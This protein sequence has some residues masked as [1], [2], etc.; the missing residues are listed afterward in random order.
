ML[1]RRPTFP[2]FLEAPIFSTLQHFNFSTQI[3]AMQ[4]II[5]GLFLFFAHFLLQAQ[6]LPA[7]KSLIW[8]ISG[9]GLKKNSYLYGT[10]HLI[11]RKDFFMHKSTKEAFK[12]TEKVTFEID[13]KEMENIFA[14]IPL[15]MQSFMK[16]DTSLRDL[17]PAEDYKLV[18]KHFSEIGL[19][20]FMINRIKPMFLSS[21]DPEM[22]SG[23]NEGKADTEMTSYEAEFLE[24]AEADKKEVNG[25]ETA[26]FQMSMF[27]SIPYKVQAEMLVES[28]KKG[29]GESDAEFDKMVDLYKQQDIQALQN[30]INQDDMNNYSALMLD[31]RNKKWIP[32]MEKMMRQNAHFFAVGAGHLG[33]AMGVIA[34]LR[35]AGYQVRAFKE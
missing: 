30:L 10:I 27:D 15:L 26:A 16:K 22:I 25:L 19:P 33:G 13:L 5:T 34:L 28:I 23:G 24:M 21:L 4:Y 12:K 20:M 7:E 35:E 31:N 11:D 2:T 14:L 18:E 6:D 29:K 8:E 1:K 32:L 17:L 3:I 9:N